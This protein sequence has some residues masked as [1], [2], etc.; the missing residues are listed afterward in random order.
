MKTKL[1]TFTIYSILFESIVWGLF[2]WAVFIKGHS[3][4]W[5][6]VALLLSGAQLKPK[7]FGITEGVGS[8]E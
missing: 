8:E 4:W 2:G 6:L 5:V 3:G 1:I 7:H